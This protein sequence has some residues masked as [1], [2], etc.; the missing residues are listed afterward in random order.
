MTH[1][2]QRISIADYE[3][4]GMYNLQVTDAGCVLGGLSASSIALIPAKSLEY[5]KPDAVR[6]IPPHLIKVKV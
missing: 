4:P 5:L 1:T 6:C 3:I 2:I